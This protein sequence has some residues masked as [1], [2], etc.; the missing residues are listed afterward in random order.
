MT[1]ALI[2]H[3]GFVGSNLLRQQQFDD[4]YN[5]TNIDTIEVKDYNLVVCAGTPAAKWIANREPA[6]DRENIQ[7]LTRHLAAVKAGKFVLISTVDV[8]PVPLGVD[9]ESLVDMEKCEPYGKHRLELEHFVADR[10]D[11]CIVRL[12]GLFGTGLKKNVIYDLLHD[13]NLNLINP[14]GVFQF[15]SLEHLTRDINVAL[16]S[17]LK[18]IN[19]TSEPVSVAEVAYVCLEHEFAN[20]IDGP[21]ARYDYLSRY[22]HLFGGHNGYLYSKQQVLADLQAYVSEVRRGAQ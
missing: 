3:T 11:A 21:A 15:Y 17:N 5:S 13:N 18:V 8:Y 6:K 4:C 7:Q 9:E 20:D 10:F 1:N 22:A 14:R 16:Q 19:I 2:G 12:P